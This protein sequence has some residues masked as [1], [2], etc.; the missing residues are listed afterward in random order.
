MRVSAY[1]W[2]G[3]RTQDLDSAVRFFS[4]VLGLPMALRDDTRE[5]AVFHLS[6]GQEFEVFG[7]RC[8]W[9]QF[10]TCPVI[11]FEVEDVHAARKELEAKGV[12]F[13]S[14]VAEYENG[15]AWSYFRGPDGHLY[16][17]QRPAR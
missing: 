11:G 5:V 15:A 8:E 7:P 14:E 16:E 6:S 13:V 17:I 2:A 3:V 12:E 4:E 10:H 1:S 9:Y